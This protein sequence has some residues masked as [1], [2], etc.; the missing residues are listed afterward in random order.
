[1]I[2]AVPARRPL[3]LTLALLLLGIVWTALIVSVRDLGFNVELPRTRLAIE[4]ASA[5]VAL[6]TAA[7][8]FVRGSVAGPKAWWYVGTAFLILGLNRLVFGVILHPDVLGPSFSFYVWTVGRVLAALL[9]LTAGLRRFRTPSEPLRLRRALVSIAG[10][11]VAFME[12]TAVVLWSTRER[13]PALSSIA[14]DPAEVSGVLPGI[15]GTVV[16]LGAAGTVLFLV[17]AFLHQRPVEGTLVSFWLAPTLVL[18]ALSQVHSTLAPATFSGNIATG[19]LLRLGFSLLLLIGIVY[20]VRTAYKGERDRSRQLASAYLVERARV[21]DMESLERAKEEFFSILTHELMHPV[22][23]LR[24]L[25][26]TLNAKWEGLDEATKRQFVGRL[27]QETG[28]LRDLAE[29]SMSTVHLEDRTFAIA[30]RPEVVADLTRE[31]A[32]ANAELA[33]RLRVT[34][35]DGAGDA[36][37]LADRTRLLQVMRN[38]LSNAAKYS[39]ADAPIEL[40]VGATEDAVAFSV[41]DRGPGIPEEALPR[42]FQRFSRLP[43]A[44]QVAGSGLGLYISKSIVE[45]HGG[46]I[47]V[48]SQMGDG[49]S[50]TFTIPRKAPR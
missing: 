29:A 23:A 30:A 48:E 32:E 47:W 37:V 8:A 38:L 31:V 27:E 5:T 43:G 15:G 39:D 45:A 21:E 19:D 16:A 22:A 49:T 4:A 14:V 12:V 28:R 40:S 33:P 44:E 18:A 7:V 1:M 25:A 11:A 9:L 41:K 35:D 42:L 20:D 10:P 6:M 26:V 24:G 50:V 34:V 2:R 46:R 17:A 3:R 36:V 13:L